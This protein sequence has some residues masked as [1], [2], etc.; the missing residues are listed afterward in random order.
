M[1]EVALPWIAM[2]PLIK[3]QMVFQPKRPG[4][5]GA[6]R[7]FRKARDHQVKVF[8][9]KTIRCTSGITRSDIEREANVVSH[10]LKAG[11]HKNIVTI[12]DQGWIKNVLNCYFI[13]MELCELTLHDYT[14][15]HHTSTP[16][17]ASIETLLPNDTITVIHRTTNYI[18]STVGPALVSKSCSAS[19]M[20]H[21]LWTIGAHIAG[22]LEF[23]HSHHFA[24]RDLKPRNGITL[25]VQ[26]INSSPLLSSRWPM[27]ADRL[28]NFC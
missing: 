11:G 5:T 20:A 18:T 6:F 17:V 2:D 24:H 13:D 23:M 7:P 21:N 26:N 8:A 27:E 9:R 3:E 19:V 4:I 28:R 22:G 14:W 12:L 25:Q 16:S 10:L 15:Y 1:Y